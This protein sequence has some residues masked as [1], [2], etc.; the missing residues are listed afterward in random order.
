M[1][2][3]PPFFLFNNHLE[4]IYPALLRRVALQPYLRERIATPDNDFLDLDW[5]KQGAE[6]VVIISHGLEGNTTRAYI[7]GMAKTMLDEGFDVLAWNYRGCS[8]EINQQKRFYHSG[9]TD[10]LEV[11]ISHVLSQGYHS[12][13][14]I[15]FSLG[16]NITLKY[17]GEDRSKHPEIKKATALSVPMDLGASCDTISKPEN[18]LYSRRFLKSLAEKVERKATVRKDI[19]PAPLSNIKTLREFDDAYT[20]PLHGFKNAADYY[21]QCS[22]IHFVNRILIPTLIVNAENDPFLS[23]ECYPIDLLKNH[24]SVI[25]E[26]PAHGGHVGFAQFGQNGLYWSEQRTLQFLK[27]D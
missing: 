5:I 20:A 17:L 10:D 16:G 6:K 1:E 19:D 27:Y 2:Y 14:L 24:A 21:H 7:K 23:K 9:A 15:G 12:I 8:E 25:L 22:S 3:V 26:V 13:Y 11:V 18:F 4:T